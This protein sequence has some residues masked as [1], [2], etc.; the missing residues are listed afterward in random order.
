MQV[1]ISLRS[2]SGHRLSIG[3]TNLVGTPPTK[4]EE[5]GS[6]QSDEEDVR[7]FFSEDISS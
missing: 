3:S 5:E 6:T 4:D 1:I 7:A 2:L